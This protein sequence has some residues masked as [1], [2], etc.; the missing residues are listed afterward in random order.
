MNNWV[1]KN[2]KSQAII[3]AKKHIES[4]HG[5]NVNEKLPPICV[6]FE[7][8]IAMKYIESNYDT[9]TIVEKL[10]CFLDKPKCIVINNIPG[11]CFLR[12]GYGAPSAVDTL[13]TII[14]LGVEKI[15]VIGMCGVYDNKIDVGEVLIPP[16]I[17]REEGTS[18]HYNNGSVWVEPDRA[19]FSSAVEFFENRIIVHK[20]N[21]V[22]TD[23]VYRQTFGKERVWREQG[24]VGVDMESSALLTVSKFYN[25]SAISILLASDKHPIDATQKDW[26]WGNVNFKKRKCEIIDLAIKYAESLQEK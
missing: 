2:D 14:A 11:V 25:V 7:I 5:H 18:Y 9:K 1:I 8:G 23:S 12:G 22:T 3:T 19:L 26:E 17:L 4:A 6:F 21:T 15:I 20:C 24:S 13:E 16:Q 10:P